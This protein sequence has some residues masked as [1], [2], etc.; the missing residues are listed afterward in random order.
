[1]RR[2]DSVQRMLADLEV[3]IT[4]YQRQEAFHAQKE[5]HH[6]EQRA[7]Y[8]AELQAARERHAALK[9]AADAVDELVTRPSVKTPV[10]AIEID[11]RKP[12]VLSKLVF[13]VIETKDPRETFGGTSL[14]EEINQTFAGR[15]PKDAQPRTVATILRRLAAE[16]YLQMVREGR[17]FHEALYRQA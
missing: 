12:I 16:G 11:A 5:S 10:A 14:A 17:A 6:R 9:A 7:L 4:S 15:L 3:R 13:R 2:E 8:A 1:M